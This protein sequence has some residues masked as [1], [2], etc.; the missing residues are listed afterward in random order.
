MV[1]TRMEDCGNIVCKET[2][3]KWSWD[4]WSGDEEIIVEPNP[5]EEASCPESPSKVTGI[6]I[7]EP[8]TSPHQEWYPL[9]MY[10]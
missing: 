5:D 3:S 7:V 8:G 6:E 1:A 10:V 4:T 9:M 2:K